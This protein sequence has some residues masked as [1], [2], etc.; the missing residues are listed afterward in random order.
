MGRVYETAEDLENEKAIKEII[1]KAKP[2]KLVKAG[3]FCKIDYIM[4]DLEGNGMALVEMK[5][6]KVAS[7]Q[8]ETLLLDYAKY[9]SAIYVSRHL[10]NEPKNRP[11]DFLIFIKFLDKL[12]YY[13]YDKTHNLSVKAGGRTD[14]GDKN[15]IEP[16]VHIPMTL[17]KGLEA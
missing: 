11:L 17:F 9:E 15:D 16:C 3:Q 2:V 14:R 12:M 4:M 13:K 6:R 10:W 1:E 5:A 7:N 8:Y